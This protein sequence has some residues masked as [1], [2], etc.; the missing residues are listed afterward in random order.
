VSGAVPQGIEVLVRKAA[1]DSEFQAA[2][3]ERRAGAA[4]LIGLE[5]T[6]AEALMLN[7]VPVGQLAAII[8]HTSVP[9]EH[10]RAFLGQAA[11]AMLAALAAMAAGSVQAGGSGLG[12]IRADPPTGWSGGIRPKDS[13]PGRPPS[14]QKQPDSVPVP[15]DEELQEVQSR[16]LAVVTRRFKVNGKDISRDTSFTK[17]LKAQPAELVKLKAE[18]EKE[19]QV[20]IPG[21]SFKD[22]RTVGNAIDYLLRV[23]PKRDPQPSPSFPVFGAA[24]N[25][26]PPGMGGSLGIR[27]D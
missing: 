4:E 16:V 20:K 9:H 8:S 18:L 27:P 25:P 15:S 17:D 22:I 13:A 7:A 11:A 5:L 19:F 23:R 26:P 12:G 24:P 6:P 10:R 14:R 3:L 1:V 2:L 21:K